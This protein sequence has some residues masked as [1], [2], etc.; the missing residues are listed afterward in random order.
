M[1][2]IDCKGLCNDQCSVIPVSD[3]DLVRL[4]AVVNP[5][6][7]RVA[8]GISILAVDHHGKCRLL[9]DGRCTAYQARPTICRLYGVAE[10]LECPHGCEPS[11]KLTR[12]EA[13]QLMRE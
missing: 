10:G 7:T 1:P 13:A 8:T 4:R 2:T 5:R 6:S 3:R 9:A 12:C 11:R